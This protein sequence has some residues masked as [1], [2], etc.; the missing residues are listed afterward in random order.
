MSSLKITFKVEGLVI[1]AVKLMKLPKFLG[2]ILIQVLNI[3]EARRLHLYC[4]RRYPIL[5]QRGLALVF[6]H[7]LIHCLFM[8]RIVIDF[9]VCL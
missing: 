2:G 7:C 3:G 4:Q 1:N 5:F 9:E 6:D 8:G